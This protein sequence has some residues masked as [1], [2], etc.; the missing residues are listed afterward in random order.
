MAGVIGEGE[1]GDTNLVPRSRSVRGCRNDHGR[2]GYEIKATQNKGG[3]G[4]LRR[5]RRLSTSML[6]RHWYVPLHSLDPVV[7]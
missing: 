3:F 5:P 2:A 1:G 6:R 4:Q 7:Q